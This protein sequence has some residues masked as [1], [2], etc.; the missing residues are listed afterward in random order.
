MRRNEDKKRWF[1][2]DRSAPKDRNPQVALDQALQAL[3]KENPRLHKLVEMRFDG[4]Y[5]I[6]EV[7]KILKME[8]A[9]A[10]RC[11]A[12]ARRFLQLHVQGA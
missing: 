4:R 11:W 10:K 8:I 1:R 5:A 3:E 12:Q 6:C 7:A 9:T 2:R